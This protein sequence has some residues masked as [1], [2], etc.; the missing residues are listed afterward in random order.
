MRAK[1]G[2]L[3]HF[4]KMPEKQLMGLGNFQTLSWPDLVFRLTWMFLV[5]YDG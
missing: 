1:N 2:K 3:A 4:K 5:S